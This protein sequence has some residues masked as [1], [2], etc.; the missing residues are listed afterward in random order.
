MAKVK[1]KVR[2]LD[3]FDHV[4]WYE[5]GKEYDFKD[6]ARVKNL[7]SKGW[8]EVVP[9]TPP[10]TQPVMVK[11]FGEEWEKEAVADALRSL[12][13]TVHH[14]AGAPKL[15]AILAALSDED[16]SKIREIFGIEE[17]QKPSDPTAENVELIDGTFIEIVTN[18]DGSMLAFGEDNGEKVLLASGEYRSATHIYT[19]GDAG[20]VSVAEIDPKDE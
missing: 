9:E 13:K 2:F 5:V 16:K 14:A 18:P 1:V 17:P 20:A 19:V 6:E 8:V 3:K 15:E 11:V 10:V 7:V 12:G 4:T